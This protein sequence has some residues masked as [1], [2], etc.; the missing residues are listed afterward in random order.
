VAIEVFN[1]LADN[2]LA[3]NSFVQHGFREGVISSFDVVINHISKE[4]TAD[5]HWHMEMR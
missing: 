3:A 1:I 5:S 2:L 4:G